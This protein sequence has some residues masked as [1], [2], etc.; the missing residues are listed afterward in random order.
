VF[1]ST[2]RQARTDLRQQETVQVAFIAGASRSGSTLLERILEQVD[3]VVTVGELRWLW[4]ARWPSMVCECGA[5]FGACQFWQGV[6]VEA[7]GS[8]HQDARARVRELKTRV[9]RHRFATRFTASG[10]GGQVGS[11]LAEISSL[12][13]RLYGAL[14]LSTGASTIVD[15]GKLPLWGL[16]ASMS[17]TLDLRV[18]HLVRDPR[19]VSFSWT[20]VRE[21]PYLPG[22]PMPTQGPL[23]SA[24]DWVT[25]NSEAE[26][27]KRR[28]PESMLVLY[29][30]L[31]RDPGSTV[32]RV[33]KLLDLDADV[34]T[35]FANRSILRP[36]RSGHAI[37]GNPMRAQEGP[38][39]IAPDDEWRSS[40]SRKRRLTAMLCTGPLWHHYRRRAATHAR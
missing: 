2:G 27:L 35:L 37:A 31:A 6:L 21:L 13:T 25:A 17:P 23:R 10:P 26:I 9:L 1:P 8:G 18:V 22:T 34:D 12:L 24:L 28:V 39:V 36:A 5:E 20:R 11:E 15:A 38:I 4:L 33:V 19:A 16:V 7:F 32:R 40:L 14:S 30:D 29:G 3:G